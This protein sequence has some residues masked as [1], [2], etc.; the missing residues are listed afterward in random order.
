MS[1]G[2]ELALQ[3]LRAAVNGDD[4][5]F[6]INGASPFDDCKI[7]IEEMDRLRAPQSTTMR[8][9]EERVISAACQLIDAHTYVHPTLTRENAVNAATAE[10]YEAVGKWHGSQPAKAAVTTGQEKS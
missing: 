9:I 8:A 10:L 4:F 6:E 3:R 1:E 5:A 7:L 2:I